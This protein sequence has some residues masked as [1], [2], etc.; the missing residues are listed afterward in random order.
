MASVF[1]YHVVGDLTVGKPELVEFTE[2]ETVEAAIRAIGESTDCGIAVWKQKENAEMR[3]Q[4]FLGILNPLDIVA[5][6]ARDDCL[7][8]QDKALNTPVSEFLVPDN[9]LLKEVDPGTRLIDALEIMK[10]GVRRL[11]VPKS[12][13]W[14]G[15]S[16]RFSILYNGKWLKNIDSNPH[17]TIPNINRSSSSTPATIIRDKYCCLSREDVIRFLI[18]CL[19]AL[20]PLP[21]SSI[22]SL[23][24]INP[25]YRSIE[26]SSPAI[27]AARKIPREPS[28]FAV[29][30]PTPD[31]QHKIIGEISA[32]KLWKCDYLAAAWALANLSAGQFVT[33]VE[34]NQ[35]SRYLPD[36]VAADGAGA[37]SGGRV[38]RQR[39]FSSRSIGI[40]NHNPSSQSFG[41][42]RSMYRGR[43]VP[44]TC[45]TTSSLA[46]VMAQML[47]HRATHVWVTETENDDVLVGL[48]GYADILAAVTRPPAAPVP[49]VQ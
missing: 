12:I 21:L 37:A 28:A 10:H 32:S 31:G 43:S 7:N 15:M 36:L 20:A 46:A 25:K 18:G 14:R 42:N 5:F 24:A 44:L 6:L 17:I 48:V 11:L 3:H 1:L 33:G 49:E 34:D 40:F 26:A 27:E 45:K 2:N 38:I 39:T 35:S 19:G 23:G 22:S 41:V 30:D 16:K 4:R 13:G 8:D 47:S 9:T 29:V